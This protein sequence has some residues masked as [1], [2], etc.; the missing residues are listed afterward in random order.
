LHRRAD[1]SCSRARVL[2]APESTGESAKAISCLMYYTVV[3][4]D[5]G[6]IKLPEDDY[7][8][9]NERRKSLGLTWSEYLDGNAPDVE[10]R[11]ADALETIAGTLLM[12][13]SDDR[14]LNPEAL[15]REA[16]FHYDPEDSGL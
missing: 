1:T 15:L 12:S 4:M 10:E 5:R 3:Q 2:Y 8:R 14:Q 6:T 9:H 11:K 7:E 13:E 16:R